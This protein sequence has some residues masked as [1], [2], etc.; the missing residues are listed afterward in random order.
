MT[1]RLP[2]ST[3]RRY[4]SGADWIINMIDYANKKA[5]GVG[6][7]SQVVMEL[8]GCPPLDDLRERLDT[9]LN[10]YPIVN[11]QVKRDYCNLAP[12]W[13]FDQKK[14]RS[15]KL[16]T[17]KLNGNADSQLLAKLEQT[18][19]QPFD[20]DR[21]HLSF[22]LISAKDRSF[23]VMTFDH[24]LLDARG[25][26]AFLNMF[27]LEQEQPG[28][29]HKKVSVRESA[30]L[31]R[32]HEQFEAG[33]N[34]SRALKAMSDNEQP[35]FPVSKEQ[36]KKGFKFK[37]VSFDKE[38]TTH[39]VKKAYA[40]AG[41]LLIMPYIL[42]VAAQALHKTFQRNNILAG[43]Y[44]IPVSTDM[45]AKDRLPEKTFF[46]YVSFFIFRIPSSK[47]E[48]FSYLL[49]T[50][51]KQMYDQVKSKNLQ[52]FNEA[53]YLLRI[54]PLAILGPL[55]RLLKQWPSG[56]FCS[57]YVGEDTYGFSKF[58]NEDVLNIFHMPRPPANPGLGVYFNQ[59]QGRLNATLSYMNG[60]L[61][62]DDVDSIVQDIKSNLKH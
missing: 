55:M 37:I 31:D 41:Y 25:A 19:N 1:F 61:A 2:Y 3:N 32:W 8:A 20:C 4:L 6:N 5:T 15:T 16:K 17:Y 42:A 11:G 62:E 34:T 57:S 14:R 27:Q 29:H 51:K 56:S 9:F 26:E 18:A 59:F 24:R 48:D 21:E 36:K 38:E 28:M 45:R 22:C 54:V 47:T 53:S 52:N 33:R 58:M 35:V 40:Q 49:D 30:H 12:Y 23:L 44:I 10:H 46:N 50:I 13:K 43:D 39:I 7:Q 60:M